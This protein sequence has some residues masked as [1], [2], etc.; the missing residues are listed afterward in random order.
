MEIS[1]T[2]ILNS[3]NSRSEKARLI[4]DKIRLAK[5]YRWAGV[6]DVK[7]KEKGS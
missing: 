3:N 5:G 7:E 1:F 2:D 4:A 6:Y